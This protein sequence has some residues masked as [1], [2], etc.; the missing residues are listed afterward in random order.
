MSGSRE[1]E[2]WPSVPPPRDAGASPRTLV[3]GLGNPVLGDDGVGWRVAHVCAR[4]LSDRPDIRVARFARGGLSLMEEL[5]GY[6]RVILIDAIDSGAAPA[7]SVRCFPLEQLRNTTDGHTTSPHDTSLQTALQLGRTLGA[8]LPDQV[9]VVA[10]EAE[11]TY[12][13]SEELSPAVAAAVPLAVAQVLS[14]LDPALTS[15][16]TG[17][18]PVHP[19][20]GMDRSQ[21]CT[22]AEYTTDRG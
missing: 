18:R 20:G 11:V 14:Q 5:V 16:T 22:T 7:G 8:A 21:R 10:V 6:E 12:D 13:L 19:T 17:T 3:L 2:E 9:L 1:N 4:R 15:L